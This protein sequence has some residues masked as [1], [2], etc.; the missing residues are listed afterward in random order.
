[1][2][3]LT[4]FYLGYQ[5][6][7]SS[8]QCCYVSGNYFCAPRTQNCRGF[9]YGNDF[10]KCQAKE[11]ADDTALGRVAGKTTQAGNTFRTQPRSA[12]DN[13]FRSPRPIN[14]VFSDIY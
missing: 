3:I 13:F 2:Q 11:T 1:M 8:E 14:L 5:C 7:N 10:E 6:S 12:M 4:L 9:S